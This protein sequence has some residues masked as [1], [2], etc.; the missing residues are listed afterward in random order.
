M[1][2]SYYSLDCIYLYFVMDDDMNADSNGLWT[3]GIGV[4]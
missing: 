1:I 4:Y 3:C 2:I